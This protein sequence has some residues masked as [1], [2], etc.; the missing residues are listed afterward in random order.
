MNQETS[1]NWRKKTQTLI[2]NKNTDYILMSFI[3]MAIIFYIYFAGTAVHTLTILEK[4]K[5][6][7]QSLTIKVGDLESERLLVE[8]KIN[9]QTALQMGLV[10]VDHP[11]FIM[12]NSK[13]TSLSMKID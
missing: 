7:M 1:A 8:N 5:Q 4:T 10:E 12:K 9:T 13:R 11:T 3:F 2:L 6:Q